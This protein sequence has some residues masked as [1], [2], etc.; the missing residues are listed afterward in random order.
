MQKVKK[1]IEEIRFALLNGGDS[2]AP[3]LSL[4][5]AD[6]A[7]VLEELSEEE[8]EHI[9][10][11]LDTET[12]AS[13][14]EELPED[15]AAELI[16]ELSPEGIAEILDETSHDVAADI[17]SQLPEDQ[18]TS[19][20][21]E[22][23][24]ADEVRPLLQYPPESA[25]GLMTTVDFVLKK[26]QTAAEVIEAIRKYE[27]DANSPY[28]LYVTDDIGKLVGVIGLRSLIVSPPNAKVEEFMVSDVHK[29]NVLADQEEVA[30]MMKRYR[31]ALV[32]V[33]DNEERLLGAIF[34]DDIAYILEEEA[35]EDMYKLANI[36]DTDIQV[37]SPVAFSIKRRLPWLV[38]NLATAFLAASVVYFFEETI[39]RAAVLAAFLGIVAGQGG[40]NGSQTVAILIR[41]IALGQVEL[42][43][44][45]EVLKKEI[46]VCLVNGAVIG[47]AVGLGAWV[48]QGNPAL[49]LVVAL[50]MI[51]NMVVS[52]LAGT[53]IPLGLKALRF[54]P[55]ASSQIF[56]TTI[57]DSLGFGLILGLA[58]VAMWQFGVNF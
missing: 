46:L 20:L 36:S 27:V 38:V 52:G 56:L 3:F 44:V 8:R 5:A 16:D 41:G 2:V 22:M 58:A 42:K 31:L 45:R 48:W 6:Q 55:A 23:E 14:L 28:Y 24:D 30:Q 47:A 21:K 51:M 49:G 11:N 1:A 15:E 54:D 43:D 37:W 57:T 29:V 13:L 12:R 40:N 26:D 33:I 50:A 35:T 39:Q 18:A 9:F 17:L 34:S 25:G 10:A 7:Q 19:A 4:E 53:V 32:P